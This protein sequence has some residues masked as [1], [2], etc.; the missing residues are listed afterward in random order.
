MVLSNNLKEEIVRR[1]VQGM[2]PEKIFLFGSQAWGMPGPDSDVD[3]MIVV[4]ESGQRPAKRAALAYKILGGLGFSKDILVKTRAEF[5][6]YKNIAASLESKI[7]KKG[8]LLYG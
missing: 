4:S 8:V 5:D 1:L 3:L 7:L 6:K 2:N